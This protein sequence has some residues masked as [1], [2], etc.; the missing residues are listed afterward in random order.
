M[1]LPLALVDVSA[2]TPST[3]YLIE[4]AHG[5][6]LALCF[7]RLTA[8]RFCSALGVPTEGE[9]DPLAD[10]RLGVVTGEVCP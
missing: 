9:L 7:T 1:I 10:R 2:L 8:E 6:P 3:P 5:T 4:D